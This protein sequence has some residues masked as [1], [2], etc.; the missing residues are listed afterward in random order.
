MVFIVIHMEFAILL[1]M[2]MG[3]ISDVKVE[4]GLCFCCGGEVGMVSTCFLRIRSRPELGINQAEEEVLVG[5]DPV[6]HPL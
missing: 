6:V 4:L 3:S 1:R 5:F 2:R